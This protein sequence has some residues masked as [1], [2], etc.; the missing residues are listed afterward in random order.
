VNP[1]HK[2]LAQAIRR[3]LRRQDKAVMD[4]NDSVKC[5]G[6]LIDALD[7]RATTNRHGGSI[8]GCRGCPDAVREYGGQG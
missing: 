6:A 8:G 1:R 3:L 7:R 4:I 5:L 2:H